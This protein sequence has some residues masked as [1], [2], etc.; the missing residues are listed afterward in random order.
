MEKKKSWASH[1]H[2]YHF[3]YSFQIHPWR[4]FVLIKSWTGGLFCEFFFSLDVH[5]STYI[6]SIDI[7]KTHHLFFLYLIHIA[8]ASSLVA[9]HTFLLY[10]TPSKSG[11]IIAGIYVCTYEKE[12]IRKA[13]Q[14]DHINEHYYYLGTWILHSP[15]AQPHHHRDHHQQYP[16]LKK[17]K[18]VSMYRYGRWCV[19][20]WRLHRR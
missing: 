7:W 4:L 1:H 2:H 14:A 8:L 11:I 15:P 13:M 9:K 19:V 6:S 17:S 20:T 5:I 16:P 10:E 12:N 3:L 18:N